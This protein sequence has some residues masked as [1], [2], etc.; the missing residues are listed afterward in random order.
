MDGQTTGGLRERILAADDSSLHAVEVPGWGCTVYV[1]AVTVAD[2]DA[3]S[4]AD[5]EEKITVEK[6]AARVALDEQGRRIFSDAD[7]ELIAGRS[8]KALNRV[9][10]AFNAL[11]GDAEKKLPTPA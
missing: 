11:N 8:I 3:I 2:F 6:L 4:R 9:L 5:N 1:R 7:A 10:D